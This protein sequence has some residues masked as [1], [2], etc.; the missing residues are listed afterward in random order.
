MRGRPDIISL[1]YGLRTSSVQFWTNVCLSKA[2][3]QKESLIPVALLVFRSPK[4]TPREYIYYPSGTK[5]MIGP[6]K[7][8]P[9]R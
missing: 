1:G 7:G 4:A 2:L 3:Q 8:A 9:L 6:P 5:R